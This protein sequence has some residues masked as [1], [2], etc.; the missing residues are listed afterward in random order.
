MK[1]MQADP[2]KFKAFA[3]PFLELDPSIAE[4]AYAGNASMYYGTPLL[5]EAQFKTNIDF[6]DVANK[7]AGLDP[8]P[9]SL[10]FASMYDPSLAEEAMKRL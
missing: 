4:T 2:A 7:T 5:T 6:I 1:S 8:M 3:L 9:P 10:T